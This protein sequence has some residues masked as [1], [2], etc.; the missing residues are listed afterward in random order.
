MVAKNFYGVALKATNGKPL[1]IRSAEEL[2]V[3]FAQERD[4]Q[5]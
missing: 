1:A 3:R 2:G 5:Y 4:E